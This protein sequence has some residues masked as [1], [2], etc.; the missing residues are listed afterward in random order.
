MKDKRAKNGIRV[1]IV[2]GILFI[3]GLFV[4]SRVLN[5]YDIG[6]PTAAEKARLVNSTEGNAN[7]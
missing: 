2:G 3:V 5:H 4:L 1:I 7:E 6:E